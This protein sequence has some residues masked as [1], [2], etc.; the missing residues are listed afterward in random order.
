MCPVLFHICKDLGPL[1]F[2]I[3]CFFLSFQNP[4]NLS[5]CPVLVFSCPFILLSYI[6]MTSRT[7]LLAVYNSS[8]F[9]PSP[10]PG[11]LHWGSMFESCA[12]SRQSP[13][14][15]ETLN[16]KQ[17]YWKPLQLKNYE[18]PPSRMRVKNNGHSGKMGR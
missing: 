16:V 5:Q 1:H 15:I 12:G 4:C 8:T 18:V 14:N 13:I 7:I 3:P 6:C 9:F 10:P 17:E 11:P 2:L